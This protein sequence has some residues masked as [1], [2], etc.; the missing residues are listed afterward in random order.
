[1]CGPNFCSM[2]ITHD[3]RDSTAEPAPC[4]PETTHPGD[5]KES[6]ER[7]YPTP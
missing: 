2:K 4:N 7:G 5:E 3:L 1:M 6:A